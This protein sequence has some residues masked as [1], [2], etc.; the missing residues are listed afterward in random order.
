MGR[1]SLVY[2]KDRLELRKRT[3]KNIIDSLEKIGI[4]SSE[5]HRI[6]EKTHGLYSALK[7]KLFNDVTHNVP[8]W[9]KGH[10]DVVMAALLCGKWTESEGDKIV[11][12]EL[13]GKNMMIA[14]KNY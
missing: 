14:K 12:E 5:A 8:E 7:K 4:E 2:S 9:V 1:T 11:F 3:R 13:S 10:S 6:V